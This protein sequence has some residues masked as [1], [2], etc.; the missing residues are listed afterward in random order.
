[1]SSLVQDDALRSL[2]ETLRGELLLPGDD[3]YE[4]ARRVFNGMIDKRPAAIA[5]VRGTSDVIAA[6]AYA[7]DRGLPVGVRGGGHNVAGHGTCDDGL[8]I[9]FSMM[10]GARVDLASQTVRADPGCNWI[11]FD[12]E[13]SAHGLATTGGTVGSTGIAGLTLGG[14]LGFL[15]GSYGLTCDN[16]VSADV[17]TADGSFLT[18]NDENHEDLFWGIRGGGGNFGVV[19][20]F[21]YCLHPVDR[22]L[23]G[24]VAYPFEQARAALELF[25]EVTAVAPDELSCA[26]VMVTVPDGGPRIA[27]IAACYNGSIE[28]GEKIVAPIRRLGPPL[29]DGIRPMTYPEVQRIFA[30][31][32]F[33][34]QNYWKGHFLRDMPDAAIDA[35][36]ESFEGV[37]SDHSAILIEAPHGAV[38]RVPDDATAFGQR[39]ARFNASALAVWEGPTDPDRHVRWVR[40]YADAVAPYASGDYVNYLAD[41]ASSAEVASAYG[42]RRFERLVALKNRYDP[43]NV[44]RFNANIAPTPPG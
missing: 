18:A 19:T 32:P 15:M 24:L 11:D 41:D 20:S 9:D 27:A 16:L 8:L 10:R 23:A 38:R 43:S 29:D 26:F 42:P 34:L 17:V 35:A 14:G 28:D 22:L 21:E 4:I 40:D 5:R 25:R 33:G 1:M 13:T 2:S 44:F 37:T 7:R 30:E 6:I 12:T 39:Q 31:I 3:G 36:V